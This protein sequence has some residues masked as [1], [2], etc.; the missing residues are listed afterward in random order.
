[1]N[2]DGGFVFCLGW[3]FVFIKNHVLVAMPRGSTNINCD[4]HNNILH[5]PC[6][7]SASRTL[8]EFI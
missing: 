4:Y 5:F 6:M 3:W 1:M 7:Q 8:K 2:K